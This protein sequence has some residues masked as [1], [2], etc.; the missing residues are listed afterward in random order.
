VFAVR[1]SNNPYLGHREKLG[2]G[3]L[4]EYVWETYGKA[5][6]D[7]AA[8]G[9]GLVS[10]CGLISQGQGH[11]QARVGIYSVNRPEWIKTLLVSVTTAFSPSPFL[12]LNEHVL[13]D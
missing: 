6:G 8:I 1:Y 11:A 4:G 9:N 10:V 12:S 2:N 3:E 7:V 5:A 13:C